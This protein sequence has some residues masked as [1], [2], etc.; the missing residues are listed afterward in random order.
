MN[1]N[2][3][4]QAKGT[5]FCAL[6]AFVVSPNALLV[7]KLED[8]DPFAMQFYSYI[9]Y[10]GAVGIVIACI[11]GRNT[12]RKFKSIGW[13]G[14]LA[15]LVYGALLILLTI[16]FQKTAAANALVILAANP[17]FSAALSYFILKETIP[18]RTIIAS[19]AC[20]GAIVLI[21]ATQLGK[22]SNSSSSSN[23]SGSNQVEGIV[24]ALAASFLMAAYFIIL[25][26]VEMK[27]ADQKPDML[28]CVVIS[29]LFGAYS[30]LILF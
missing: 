1:I 18:I 11:E 3:S 17:M 26:Y 7:R 25:S 29:G 20:F 22:N 13:L 23:S 28:P 4:N 8:V 19:L 15:G 21:F 24:C 30:K 2:L 16:A 12:P 14:L 6:G 10:A 9:I 5:L 27:Y